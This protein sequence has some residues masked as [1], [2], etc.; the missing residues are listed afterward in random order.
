MGFHF[1]L[2]NHSLKAVP[3]ALF[4]GFWNAGERA[5]VAVKPQGLDESAGGRTMDG[6]YR[7]RIQTI[8]NASD[9]FPEQ[10]AALEDAASIGDRGCLSGIEQAAMNTLDVIDQLRG[11]VKKQ[12]FP[13]AVA[14]FRRI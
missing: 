9:K 13:F 14:L 10:K 5:E 12:A 1:H 3:Q 6:R 8:V 4:L 7:A 11:S 2:N